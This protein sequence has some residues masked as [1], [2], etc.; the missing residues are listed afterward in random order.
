M[1]HSMQSFTPTTKLEQLFYSEALQNLNTI[2]KLRRDRMN[3]LNSIIPDQLITALIIGVIILTF[4][5]G[6]MRGQSRFIDLIPI[7]IFAVVLGFHLSIALSLDF[8]FSGDISVKNT[9]FN[10]GILNTFKD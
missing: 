9:F 10:K 2:Q 7:I 4:I 1:Y 5:L 6:L 8:P 3:Q